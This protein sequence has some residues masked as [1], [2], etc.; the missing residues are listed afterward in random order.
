MTPSRHEDAALAGAIHYPIT[1]TPAGPGCTHYTLRNA[2]DARVVISDR[3]ATLVS[4]LAPDRYGRVADIMLG[5]PD[6]GGY[7]RNP[8]FFGG[9]IGRWGNRIAGARFML[10]G[11]DY[12]VDHNEGENHLHG[13]DTGFHLAMWQ[14]RVESGGLRLTHT[15]PEGDAGFP[16]TLQ[17]A[18][19]YSFDDNGCLSIDYTATSDAPTPINLTSHGYFNLN[20]GTGDIYDHILSIDADHYLAIDAQAIP[21]GIADV[22]SSAFDFRQ[23]APIG[24]RLTWP[25]PQLALG[26]GFDHCFCLNPLRTGATSEHVLREAATVFDPGSGR[27][28]TVATTEPGLQ[29]YSGNYLAG[30]QGRG[31][32]PYR[33]H[34]GFCLE[35]QAY[36]D[37][38]N[39]PHA[40]DVILRPG[41]IYRQTTT[42]T[43]GIQN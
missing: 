3:G 38:I 18:V 8:V 30:I 20:G 21:T 4:W 23:P 32:T 28:L 29:F 17:V 15:S 16:G 26:N 6:A 25:D 43:L 42:Y 7:E 14:A 11:L 10:D 5:Y 27:R 12:R 24:P 36:P 22:A 37:Q 40:E 39:G 34:D 31:Q 41:Q 33:K 35:A 13:G 9:L 1:S 2:H 19:F